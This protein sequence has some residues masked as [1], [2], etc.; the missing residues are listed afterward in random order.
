LRQKRCRF[1]GAA[2]VHGVPYVKVRGSGVFQLGNNVTLN[3]DQ[4]SNPHITSGSMSISVWDGAMLTIGDKSGISASQIVA[5]RRIEIGSET[6]IGA[7]C[8]ICDSD[9]H[10]VPL[11]SGKAVQSLP[12]RIGNRVFIGARC[13]I[14]KGVTIGDGSVVGAG[15]VVSK[16]IAPNT[17]VAGNPCRLIKTFAS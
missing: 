16:D 11:S 12:I 3:S 4:W 7:G 10:E 9:M 1:S 6:L 14:L 8:L 17:L 5:T 15:S 2:L 13:V